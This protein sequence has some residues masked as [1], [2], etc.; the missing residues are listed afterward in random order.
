MTNQKRI[1]K[2]PIEILR[3]P[4]S[5]TFDVPTPDD[6]LKV[7]EG[8]G[9]KLIFKGGN[10]TER[11]WVSVTQA[12]NMDHWE[13]TIDNDPVLPGVASRISYRDT[14]RFHPYDV[15][16]IDLHKR[17]D[18]REQEMDK[19][20]A[21]DQSTNKIDR[22]WYKN[23]QIIVPAIVGIVVAIIGA[24]STIIASFLSHSH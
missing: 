8:D 7:F 14:V 22:P 21:M 16:D 15:I 24:G 20:P 19:Q 4:L 3:P 13:G 11:M 23:S 10:D 5:R 9:V 6:L 1:P 12:G 2:K 18:Q 17:V